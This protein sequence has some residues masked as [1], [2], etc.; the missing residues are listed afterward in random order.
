MNT[1]LVDTMNID[2]SLIFAHDKN[3][4]ILEVNEEDAKNSSTEMKLQQRRRHTQRRL[5]QST[6]QTI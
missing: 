6:S 2:Q 1:N 5:H 3:K 4:I